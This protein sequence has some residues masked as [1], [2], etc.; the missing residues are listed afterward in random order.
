MARESSM[1]PPPPAGGGVKY[2]LVGLVLLGGAAGLMFG[3]RACE[4]SSPSAEPSEPAIESEP[5]PSPE[6]S[7]AMARDELYIPEA[8]PDAGPPPE[9]PRPAQARAPR[10]RPSRGWDACSG[11]VN[12]TAAAR[13]FANYRLQIRNCYERRLKV[14]NTLAGRMQLSVRVGRDGRVSGVQIGGSLR[15]REVTSCVRGIANRMRFPSPTGGCAVVQ[16][17]FTFSPQS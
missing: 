1:P 4:T 17:P 15:D 6:R 3:P 7:T 11:E 13:A 14:N 10:P 2:A 9:A 8:V 16:V 12:P 5:S